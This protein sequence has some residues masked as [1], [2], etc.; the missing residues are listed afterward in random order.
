M[1][2][3]FGMPIAII[4]KSAMGDSTVGDSTGHFTMSAGSHSVTADS[5]G[6]GVHHGAH[7]HGGSAMAMTIS[8]SADCGP[9]L[10]AWWHP[11]TAISYLLSLG[12]C[13]F[14]GILTEWL[15]HRIQRRAPRR[16]SSLSADSGDEHWTKSTKGLEWS[17][18][19]AARDCLLHAASISLHFASMLLV[20]SFNGG[21]IAATVLGLAVGRTWLGRQ[22]ASLTDGASRSSIELCH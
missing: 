22:E 20:M 18:S 14:L 3:V 13:F 11:R 19:A 15:S 17:S 2:L 6:A 21:V 9:L 10:F 7:H 4:E 8:F 5:H 12:V 1:F 16:Y